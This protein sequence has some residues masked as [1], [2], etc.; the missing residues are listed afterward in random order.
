V[1][2]AGVFTGATGSNSAPLFGRGIR[3]LGG[4]TQLLGNF[5]YRV[6]I[7][8]PAAI[9]AFADIGTAFNLR[10]SADQTFSTSFLDDDTFLPSTGFVNCQGVAV[11]AT[12]NTLAACNSNSLNPLALTGNAG[13]IVRDGRLVTRDEFTQAIQGGAQVDPLTG[14]PVGFQEVFLRGQAQSN[15]VARISESIFSRISDYRASIG[16]E[17]RVQLPVVNVP[18]RL[19]Y[20][21]NPNAR[22]GPDETLGINFN[23]KKSVFRFSIG[24]TF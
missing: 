11:R 14:L 4:D 20:A 19:I 15:T 3:F 12:L 2:S 17:L 18:F 7:F 8:G 13:L 9:A 1:S 24:R 6:P 23:E 21:Y 5:E 10:S 16:L 22:T